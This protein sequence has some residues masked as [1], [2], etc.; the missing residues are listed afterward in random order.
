M[1]QDPEFIVTLVKM[2]AF[3]LLMAGGAAGILFLF[4][5]FVPTAAPASGRQLINV[6]CT[7]PVAPKKSVALIQVPG[8]VLVVGM[9]G[10]NLS[11]L[12][13]IEDPETVAELSVS[14]APAAFPNLLS[15][16]AKKP[17]AEQ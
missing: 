13:R 15:R 7:K 2:L 9:A 12:A 10:D 4:R 14:P 16:F 8:R 17:P 6:L 5:R 1:T 3:L 11:L